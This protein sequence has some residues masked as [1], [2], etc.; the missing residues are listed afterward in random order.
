MFFLTKHKTLSKYKKYRD[1]GKV[2]NHKII[3]RFV[4]RDIILLSGKYLGLVSLVKQNALIFDNESET[5]ALMDFAINEY[6]INGNNAVH[7]YRDKVVLE[8]NIERKIL[9]ALLKSYTSL[10]KITNIKRQLNT[11]ILT[12]LLNI[13]C[14]PIEI[15][16][17]GFSQTAVAGFLMFLRIVPFPDFNITGGFGF[18][19]KDDLEEYLIKEYK[20]LA[21]RVKSSSESIKRY[22][23]FFKLYR[24]HGLET[25]FM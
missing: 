1:V 8:N 17:I 4:G 7:L 3:D 21:K 19:F 13:N 14:E 10:F 9:D 25:G 15:I 5:A 12:D 18:A 22:V 2:L 20:H 23:V 16:D 6:Q 11:L 24:R